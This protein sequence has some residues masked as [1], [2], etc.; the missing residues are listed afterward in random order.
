M[1]T[2]SEKYNASSAKIQPTTENETQSSTGDTFHKVLINNEIFT[3]RTD[4]KG[5]FLGG[6]NFGHG[7]HVFENGNINIQTGPKQYGNGKLVTISRGGQIIKTGPTIIERTGFKK[8]FLQEGEDEKI[9]AA[10]ETNYGDVLQET[11]GGTHTI[12]ADNIVI[13]AQDTLIIKG[14]GGITIDTQALLK[15]VA[16]DISEEYVTKTEEGEKLEHKVQERLMTSND[17]RSSDNIVI[18]GHINRRIGGDYDMDIGGI[19]AT[20]IQGNKALKGV[21]LVLN[22]L[23]GFHIGLNAPSAG[24]GGMNI[25]SKTGSVKINAGVDLQLKADAL[26]NISSTVGL[27]NISTGANLNLKSKTGIAMTSGGLSIPSLVDDDIT[28][29]SKNNVVIEAAKDVD[30]DSQEGKIYLN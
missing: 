1:T 9:I 22:R 17:V 14:P 5:A 16:A 25:T 7:I 18:S 15:L 27:G 20:R 10:E 11:I 2:S 3:I 24:F 13:D 28:I 12:K 6:K 8:S 23:Y 30:I 4:I 19:S 26:F 21:P 29:K